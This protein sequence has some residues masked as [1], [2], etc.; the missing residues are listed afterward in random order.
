M[1]VYKWLNAPDGTQVYSDLQQIVDQ[2]KADNE[3]EVGDDIIITV[4]E[5]TDEEFAKLTVV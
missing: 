4:V 1:T 5:M 3:I 2:I